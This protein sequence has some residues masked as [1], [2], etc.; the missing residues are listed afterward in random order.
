M[1]ENSKEV[2]VQIPDRLYAVAQKLANLEECELNQ[3]LHSILC[4]GILEAE[5]DHETGLEHDSD[6]Y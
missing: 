6:W 2:I 1:T 5:S 3:W 4:E